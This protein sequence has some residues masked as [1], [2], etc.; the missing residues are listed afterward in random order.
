MPGRRQKRG[1]EVTADVNIGSVRVP[2]R[3]RLRVPSVLQAKP[4][5]HATGPPPTGHRHP[6]LTPVLVEE[7][8]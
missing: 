5:G 6:T 4:S 2:F 8:P 3:G 1:W 7:N